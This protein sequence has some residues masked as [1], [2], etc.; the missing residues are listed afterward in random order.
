MV[1]LQ[2]LMLALLHSESE[3][4]LIILTNQESC[5]VI[6]RQ[7]LII[8]FDIGFD[9]VDQLSKDPVLLF[10]EGHV[11]L[12]LFLFDVE[13]VGYPP[14]VNICFN[15][16]L[17]SSIYASNKWLVHDV[18]VSKIWHLVASWSVAI[19]TQ[20]SFLG[21]LSC[22][23]SF[24]PSLILSEFPVTLRSFP[25]VLFFAVANFHVV[26]AFVN[27][28]EDVC[29]IVLAVYSHRLTSLDY[30]RVWVV[31]KL[32]TRITKVTPIIK[33]WWVSPYIKNSKNLL[34][35]RF[36]DRS[37]GPYHKN[38]ETYCTGTYI[39]LYLYDLHNAWHGTAT[40]C[41][42]SICDKD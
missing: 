2:F 41:I 35:F 6:W 25:I 5:E 16:R 24:D 29:H 20:L 7:V 39:P 3:I 17:H 40:C 11:L 10:A 8:F 37:G 30:V 32:W 4:N 42:T 9:F 26:L 15:T 23:C 27:G 18:L 19:A 36:H 33:I 14:F 38:N 1:Y 22:L 13:V 12:S 31:I 28:D 21:F 34:T